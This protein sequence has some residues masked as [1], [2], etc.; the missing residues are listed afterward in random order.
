MQICCHYAYALRAAYAPELNGTCFAQLNQRFLEKKHAIVKFS[1]MVLYIA[2]YVLCKSSK[3]PE[4]APPI[5][6]G[7]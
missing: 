5:K 7:I 1:G 6:F 4:N 3:I 2:P